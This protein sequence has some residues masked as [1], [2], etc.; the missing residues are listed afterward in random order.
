MRGFDPNLLEGNVTRKTTSEY[1]R[2]RRAHN[3]KGRTKKGDRFVKLDHWLLNTEAWRSLSPAARALYVELL[4]RYNGH[5]NGEI[6]LSVREAA[7]ILHIAKD[8]A[9]KAFKELEAKGFVKRHV[10]G[11]F[12]WKRR[13]ATTW[14]LTDYEFEDEPATKEFARWRPERKKFG[15]KSRTRCPEIRTP[16][17]EIERFWLSCVPDL[18]QWTTFTAFLGPNLRHAYSLPCHALF[19][20]PARPVKY[21]S[22][23]S[24]QPRHIATRK[25]WRAA[26]MEVVR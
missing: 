15:P 6:S 16:T 25:P 17:A 20:A 13:H 18:G 9:S 14:I 1:R 10:C 3:A 23:H 5:N 19:S 11:S 21:R 8:T 24:A 2:R 4:R 22:D 26:F 12:N 7:R